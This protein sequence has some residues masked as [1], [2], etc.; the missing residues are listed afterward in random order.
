MS[1]APRTGVAVV[2]RQTRTA[3]VV[4]AAV[5]A[6]CTLVAGLAQGADGLWSGVLGTV[7]VLGF[8]VAGL[9]PILR[10][11]MFER[12]GGAGMAVVLVGYVVRLVLV[13]VVVSLVVAL[14]DLHRQSLGLTVIAC[15]AAWV[16]GTAV[17]AL[18]G[19]VPL[20]VPDHS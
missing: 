8:F 16:V 3:V 12:G 11:R 20:D 19:H 9:T 6:L 4:T 15:S 10:S 14:A 1:A 5:G 18:R 7:A 13:I 17:V 2:L